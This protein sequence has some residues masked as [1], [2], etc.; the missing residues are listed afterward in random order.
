M[1]QTGKKGADKVNSAEHTEVS[2]SHGSCGRGQL[3]RNAAK[4]KTA[5]LN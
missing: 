4:Y 1:R 2:K 3:R 5:Q